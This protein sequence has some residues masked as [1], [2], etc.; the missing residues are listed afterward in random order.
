MGN[1]DLVSNLHFNIIIL[2]SQTVAHYIAVLLL[3]QYILPVFF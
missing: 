2:H 1:S 3:V